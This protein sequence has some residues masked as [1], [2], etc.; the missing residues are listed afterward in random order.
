MYYD[1]IK[2]QNQNGLIIITGQKPLILL[3]VNSGLGSTHQMDK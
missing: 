3:L 2:F 1:V